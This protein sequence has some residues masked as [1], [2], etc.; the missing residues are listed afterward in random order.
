MIMT[1]RSV[2]MAFS[3]SPQFTAKEP[4]YITINRLCATPESSMAWGEQ[5]RAVTIRERGIFGP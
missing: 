4:P 2:F 1:I 3:A 5:G